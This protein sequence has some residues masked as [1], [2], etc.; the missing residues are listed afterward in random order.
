MLRTIKPSDDAWNGYHSATSVNLTVTSQHSSHRSDDGITLGCLKASLPRVTATTAASMRYYLTLSERNVVWLPPSTMTPTYRRTGRWR[1][2]DVLIRVG[3][4]EIVLNAEK[5]HFAR[6]MVDLAGFRIFY[7]TIELLPKYMVAIRDFPTPTSTTDTRSWFGLVSQVANY[8]QLRDIMAP[9]KP[10]LSL[11]CR[12]EWIPELEI[13]FQ[14]SKE[15]II[16]E[17]RHGVEIFDQT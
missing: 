14:A 4:A 15:S 16:A 10:F 1:T 5:F 17:I 2:I 12:L 7:E 9:F 6:R 8:A 11:T 13:A 3:Q